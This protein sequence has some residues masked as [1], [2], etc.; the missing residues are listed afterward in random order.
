ML[1]AIS[2]S[3]SAKAGKKKVSNK[4]EQK[5]DQ[6]DGLWIDA[7]LMAKLYGRRSALAPSQT[8]DAESHRLLHYADVLLGTDKKDKFVATKPIKRREKE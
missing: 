4:Q 7:T 8:F 1:V 5:Q 3:M 6:A 2:A